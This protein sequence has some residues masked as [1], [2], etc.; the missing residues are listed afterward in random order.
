[1]YGLPVI[2]A[3]PQEDWSPWSS[4]SRRAIRAELYDLG[5]VLVVRSDGVV[6]T[7]GNGAGVACSPDWDFGE[8]DQLTGDAD[9]A[10]LD[11]TGAI[12]FSRT[13]VPA[14]TFDATLLAAL[15]TAGRYFAIGDT[16]PPSIS[17]D[18][19]RMATLV[20]SFAAVF[21]HAVRKA[22]P[23]PLLEPVHADLIG[24]AR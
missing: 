23:R 4:P 14:A 22:V 1:M 24:E 8:L 6:W 12:R 5:A 15:R 16:L 20:S 21:H 17:R 18:Q 7:V 11:E 2:V 19:W 3:H 9:L 13:L 10:L